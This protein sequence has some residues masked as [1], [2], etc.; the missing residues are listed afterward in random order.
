MQVGKQTATA[1]RFST[2][3]RSE[4]RQVRDL[5]LELVQALQ[6]REKD[7]IPALLIE[8]ARCAGPHF[9]YEEEALYPLLVQ[10]FGAEYVRKLFHEHDRAIA[11]AKELVAFAGAKA[12]T[13]EDWNS[14]I[15]TV[16]SILPH[17]T[18]C[19]GLSILVERLPDEQVL[20]VLAARDKAQNA[21]LDLLVWAS[22]IRRDLHTRSD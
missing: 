9:R 17:V 3:F 5:L 10:F 19:D 7:R 22:G 21:G 20:S 1:D 14:A 11:A 6:N 12:Q 8:V 16:R 13:E 2:M 4:H 18:D 15:H